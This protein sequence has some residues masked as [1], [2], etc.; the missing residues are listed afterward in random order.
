[1]IGQVQGTEDIDDGARE[2]PGFGI[3]V[4]EIDLATDGAWSVAVEVK[5][6]GQ[7]AALGLRLNLARL[8]SS[9]A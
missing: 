7:R 1:M 6:D 4:L 9:P 2:L 8:S 5:V 3:A